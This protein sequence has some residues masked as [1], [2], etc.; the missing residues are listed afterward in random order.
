MARTTIAL[1][2][3]ILED[4]SLSDTIIQS[5][6]SGANVFVTAQLDGKGLSDALLAEIERWMAAHMITHT[7]ERQIKKAGAGGAEVEYT[8]YWGTGLSGTSYGQM[9]V[10]LDTTKT[11]EALAKGKLAAW[12]KAV[13]TEN[14]YD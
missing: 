14:L 12:S 3:N 9:A 13:P 11:L 8:G 6:I 10:S 4:T 2:K 1:V 5:Y 7:V